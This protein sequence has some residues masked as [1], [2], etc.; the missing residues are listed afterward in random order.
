VQGVLPQVGRP[1]LGSGQRLD[2]EE[3]VQHRPEL[4]QSAG[5]EPPAVEAPG[6][7]LLGEHQ[8]AEQEPAEHEEEVHPGPAEGTAGPGEC[9]EHHVAA[10]LAAEVPAE[11]EDDRQ[12]ADDVEI[13]APPFPCAAVVGGSKGRGRQSSHPHRRYEFVT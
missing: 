7:R 8:A 9:V 13:E 1:R 12:S 5:G 6:T 4:Q 11:R 3:D 10:P 2:G